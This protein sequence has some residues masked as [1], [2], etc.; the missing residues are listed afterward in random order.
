MCTQNLHLVLGYNRLKKFKWSV[1]A[2]FSVHPDFKSHSGGLMMTSKMG[3]GMVSG[4]I[5]QKLNTRSSTE[6]KI[7]LTIF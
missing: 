4:S 2:T 7:A 6:A 5:K 3:G 1:D